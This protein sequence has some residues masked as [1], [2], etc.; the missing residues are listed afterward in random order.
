M[1][2]AKDNDFSFNLDCDVSQVEKNLSTVGTYIENVE[3]KLEKLNDIGIR[4][5]MIG[6]ESTEKQFK[7]FETRLSRSVE[8]IKD[9]LDI[10]RKYTSEVMNS[11]SKDSEGYGRAKFLSAYADGLE[12]LLERITETKKAEEELLKEGTFT[13]K[14]DYDMQGEIDATRTDAEAAAD[15]I[16]AMAVR[17]RQALELDGAWADNFWGDF[18]HGADSAFKEF[19]AQAQHFISEALGK[20]GSEDVESPFVEDISEEIEKTRAEEP[21][22]ADDIIDKEAP[23]QITRTVNDILQ[24]LQSL[25]NKDNLKDENGAFDDTSYRAVADQLRE[26][27]HGIAQEVGAIPEKG[28]AALASALSSFGGIMSAYDK[29]VNAEDDSVKKHKEAVK[30]W[31][32]ASSKLSSLWKMESQAQK[33]YATQLQK[34]RS[35]IAHGGKADRDKAEELRIRKD[36]LTEDRKKAQKEANDAL[37]RAKETGKEEVAAGK[38]EEEKSEKEIIAYAKLCEAIEKYIAAL[39]KKNAEEKKNATPSGGGPNNPDDVK[40]KEEQI[41][42]FNNKAKTTAKTIATI[43]NAINAAI[44]VISKMAHAFANATRMLLQFE[45]AI[46]R[47]VVGAIQKCVGGIRGLINS[48]KQTFNTMKGKL[49]RLLRYTLGL[50]GMFT[51]F[52]KLRTAI[53]QAIQ[54]LVQFDKA[55]GDGVTSVNNS[56]SMVKNSFLQLKNQIIAAFAPLINIVIPQ[57]IIP[58][59]NAVIS[60]MQKLAMFI[61]YLTGAPKWIRAKKINDDYAKSL[62]NVGGS[63]KKAANN[64]SSLDEI[65]LWQ[66]DNGGGGGGDSDKTKPEDMFEWVDTPEDM[67]RDP[68]EIARAIANI[69]NEAID[70]IP[71]RDIGETIAHYVNNSLVFVNTLLDGIHWN[72]IGEGLATTVNAILSDGKWDELGAFLVQKKN[73]L[74]ETL[75]SFF[76]NLSWV[77]LTTAITETI[78]SAIENVNVEGI[79]DLLAKVFFGAIDV[80]ARVVSNVEWDDIAEKIVTGLDNITAKADDFDWDLF[81]KKIANGLNKI[82]WSKLFSATLDAGESIFGGLMDALISFA[83]RIDTK[84]LLDAV[85]GAISRFFRG[86]VALLGQVDWNQVAHDIA[87]FIESIDFDE[88]IDAFVDFQEAFL[89]ALGATARGLVVAIP[90]IILSIQEIGAE[91]G[92]TGTDISAILLGA[93]GAGAAAS[94]LK[95]AT[96]SSLLGKSATGGLITMGV[97]LMVSITAFAIEAQDALGAGAASQIATAIAGAIGIVGVALAPSTTGFSLILTAIATVAIAG[98]TLAAASN[99][100]FEEM[101]GLADYKRE[102]EDAVSR[103]LNAEEFVVNLNTKIDLKMEDIEADFAVA[104]EL[105]NELLDTDLSQGATKQ[106]ID[107]VYDKLDLLKKL[108]GEDAYNELGM[109]FDEANGIIRT[110]ADDIQAV[111]DKQLALAKQEAYLDIIKEN[112]REMARYT[113]DIKKWE[114]NRGKY[115]EKKSDMEGV[116]DVI[117][118]ISADIY[119]AASNE[120]YFLSDDVKA[121]YGDLVSIMEEYG[122]KL[123]DTE[124]MVGTLIA[125]HDI[126]SESVKSTA[127]AIEEGDEAVQGYKDAMDDLNAT[128]EILVGEISKVGEV[129]GGE[130]EVL[131]SLRDEFDQTVSS[132]D[133]NSEAVGVW[134]DAN[135]RFVDKAHEV[136]DSMVFIRDESGKLLQVNDRVIDSYKKEEP[137]AF[138]AAIRSQGK[139]TDSVGNV[140]S[141]NDKV[142]TSDGKVI[143]VLEY[144]AQTT[145][146]KTQLMKDAIALWAQDNNKNVDEVS[147]KYGELPTVLSDKLAQMESDAQRNG[148][149]MEQLMGDNGV[150]IVKGLFMGM[151]GEWDEEELN[152]MWDSIGETLCTLLGINSP[153]TVMSEYGGYIMQGLLEGMETEFNPITEFFNSVAEAA[154][155]AFAEIPANIASGLSGMGGKIKAPLNDAITVM[156]SFIDKMIRV[157]NKFASTFNSIRTGI[158]SLP[159]T[160]KLPYLM[161]VSGFS[162]SALATGAVIPPNAPFLAMLGDQSHGRNL[163]APESLIREIMREELGTASKGGSYQ[164]VAQLNRRTL[165]EE[166]IDEAEMRQLRT[167]ENPFML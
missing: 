4:V 130:K 129:A 68:A 74:T 100:A 55:F 149:T 115:T 92:I 58:M 81:G 86:L 116:L 16:T 114:D 61:A 162:V 156:N 123:G 148:L 163:E 34:N 11:S 160:T 167:G 126:A 9:Q 67:M 111:M 153:S 28:S 135:G 12:K 165:F 104:Q 60:A 65:H 53:K 30:E 39:Q 5:K 97:G 161:Q 107:A 140:I 10:I 1:L 112:Y 48:L 110:T 42:E 76:D 52:R 89:K 85:T 157:A 113:A 2:L 106:S 15:G 47:G 23:Q 44:G 14:K 133:E 24:E 118:E 144:M 127:S 6:L 75:N 151:E 43:K 137:E 20:K 93:L 152:S 88:M 141:W 82:P 64:L 154:K 79:G 91:F 66:D 21:I 109:W 138:E 158:N 62:D 29:A 83:E 139:Y 46:G 136:V 94:G 159:N 73:I 25:F 98:I 80:A 99:K 59:M 120:D 3:K 121:S 8:S 84:D 27:I 117:D 56:I 102:L 95:I 17:I 147:Q 35:A 77:K 7:S 96:A 145:S 134:I 18:L 146:D 69:I 101:S 166:M 155:S 132:V 33:E 90:K 37:K 22:S 72:K 128:Q 124:N 122:F 142:R 38:N 54:N 87:G 103:A 40:S 41:K 164:F 19:E 71:W 57:Y 143:T 45:V 150:N 108:V 105:I 51:L 63:A 13:K 49:K 70:K 32:D 131:I 50:R 26:R 78:D 125:M 31:Q 36:N 119:E